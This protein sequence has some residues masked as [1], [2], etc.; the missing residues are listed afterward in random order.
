M[1]ESILS[2]YL[3]DNVFKSSSFPKT[4]CWAQN[5]GHWL[6][7]LHTFDVLFHCI[8]FSFS[9]KAGEFCYQSNCHSFPRDLSFSLSSL[10]IFSL[11]LTHCRFTIV[12]GVRASFYCEIPP[13]HM[14]SFFSFYQF[15]ELIAIISSN[16][17]SSF[18]PSAEY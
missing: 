7:T 5:L 3:S 9:T 15:G 18:F 6:C 12:Y 16:I 8:D 17:I 14:E 2:F 10:N 13:G 11:P 1:V 4:C